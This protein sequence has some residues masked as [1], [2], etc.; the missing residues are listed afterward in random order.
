[1]GGLLTDLEDAIVIVDVNGMSGR[2]GGGGRASMIIQ[3][4]G[5]EKVRITK[6]Q[7]GGVQ[8]EI[9][10]EDGADY[11]LNALLPKGTALQLLWRFSWRCE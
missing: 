6:Y 10:L 2:G 1:M 3:R 7:G 8:R 4:E 11:Y 9:H 5:E